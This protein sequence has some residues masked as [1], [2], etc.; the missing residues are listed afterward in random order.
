MPELKT[1]LHWLM[2]LRVVVVTLMLGLSLAFQSTRGELVPTFSALIILTYATTIVYALLLRRLSAPAAL[3]AFTW[4]QVGLD[5]VLETVLVA[6]TGGIE[7]PFAVLYVITVTVASLVPHRR[8]GLVTG[9]RC[10][11]LFGLVPAVHYLG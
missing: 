2:G 7:S 5:F 1:R 8:L 9:A 11:L 4:G 6:R 10:T 3:T